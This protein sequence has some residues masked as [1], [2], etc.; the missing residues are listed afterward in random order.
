MN[1]AITQ[2]TTQKSELEKRLE[3]IS[4][5]LQKPYT[6][7]FSDQATEREN[8]EVLEALAQKCSNEIKQID[9]ALKR[10]DDG[11]Y[12]QCS[13]CGEDINQQRL[14]AQPAAITCINCTA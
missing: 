10:V 7:D 6:K 13:S 2:L 11:S 8:D 1:A 5:D 4:K 9:A 12:G 3:A 14:A